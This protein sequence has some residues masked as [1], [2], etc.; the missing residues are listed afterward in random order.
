MTAKRSDLRER[1]RAEELEPKNLMV[2]QLQQK[3]QVWVSEFV[4]S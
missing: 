1:R 2:E 3:A 4:A